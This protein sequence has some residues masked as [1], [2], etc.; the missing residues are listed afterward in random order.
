MKVMTAINNTLRIAKVFMVDAPDPINS[1]SRY[2]V[3]QLNLLVVV[4]QNL[5]RT[6]L[7]LEAIVRSHDEMLEMA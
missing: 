5:A 1:R 4:T 7:Q 6:R 2:G 3:V